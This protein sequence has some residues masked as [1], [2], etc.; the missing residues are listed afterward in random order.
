MRRMGGLNGPGGQMDLNDLGGSDEEDE[1]DLP[2]LEWRM[3]LSNK[4]RSL[5]FFLLAYFVL[6]SLLSTWTAL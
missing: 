5:L 3:K 1:D 2:D 4:W 6:S